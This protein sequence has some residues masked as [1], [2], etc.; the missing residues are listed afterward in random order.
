MTC[1]HAYIPDVESALLE[2]TDS[3]SPASRRS[4]DAMRVCDCQSPRSRSQQIL[5]DNDMVLR[6]LFRIVKT[7]QMVMATRARTRR[8]RMSYILRSECQVQG[9]CLLNNVDLPVD[10]RDHDGQPGHSPSLRSRLT[11]PDNGGYGCAE[12]MLIGESISPDSAYFTSPESTYSPVPPPTPLHPHAVCPTK[13]R[14]STW[15]SSLRQ[16][17]CQPQQKSLS[18]SGA[19]S[20]PP[21][22]IPPESLVGC[23]A[24]VP[25]S[26][27]ELDQFLFEVWTKDTV[28]HPRSTDAPVS[29]YVRK[30]SELRLF[31]E[32]KMAELAQREAAYMSE[33]NHPYNQS[34]LPVPLQSE[35]KSLADSVKLKQVLLEAK[36][37]YKFNQLRYKLK[38]EVAETITKLRVQYIAESGRKKKG[39]PQKA[40]RLLNEWFDQHLDHPY[41]TEQEK[42]LLSARGDL[43]V[44]QVSRWF[45][46]KRSRSKAMRGIPQKVG[47]KGSVNGK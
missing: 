2:A 12:L 8:R 15:I 41:P 9:T 14:S 38:K 37:N 26:E 5:I 13:T 27:E 44:E 17:L 16:F 6:E 42:R 33:L 47:H 24:T 36:V 19:S 39:L 18:S 4:R 35:Q 21:A 31:Y 30:V 45:A 43:T 40:T 11:L 20:P 23:T 3:H 46:N 32:Q 22:L 1:A 34:A 25:E 29:H 10:S 7:Q 28:T